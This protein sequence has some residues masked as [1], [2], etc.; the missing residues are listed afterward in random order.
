[1]YTSSV[2]EAVAQMLREA[3]AFTDLIG[4]GKIFVSEDDRPWPTVGDLFCIVHPTERYNPELGKS[5]TVSSDRL[6]FSVTVGTRLSRETPKDRLATML[7]STN[8]GKNY[9]IDLLRDVIILL[10]NNNYNNIY[11]SIVSKMSS[12]TTKLPSTTSILYNNNISLLGQVEYL[13]SDATPTIRYGDYFG[14]SEDPDNPI[15]VRPAGLTLETRFQ[16]PY[17]IFRKTC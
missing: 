9:S 7:Y 3:N 10:V 4:Q 11:S 2:L 12:Y 5:S 16:A 14:S 6:M 13:S 1:M 8:S 17:L 15:S